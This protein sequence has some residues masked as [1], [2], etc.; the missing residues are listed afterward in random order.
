MLADIWAV[1]WS[2]AYPW[3]VYRECVG[4]SLL[5]FTIDFFRKEK[6]KNDPK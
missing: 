6:G 2:D 1:I 5:Y 4:L 3:V